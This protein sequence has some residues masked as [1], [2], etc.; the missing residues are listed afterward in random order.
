LIAAHDTGVPSSAPVLPASA[1]SVRERLLT[2]VIFITVLTSSI[3]FVEPSPHDALMIVLGMAA[4]IAGVRFERLLAVPLLLLMVFDVSGLLALTNDPGNTKAVLFAVI[5]IYLALAALLWACLFAQNTM[6]RL[7]TMRTAYIIT[8]VFSVFLG[9]A[10]YFHLFPDAFHLF[11]D[12]GRAKAAFKDPNVYGPFLIWPALFIMYRMLAQRIHILDVGVLA[13]LAFGL[14]L[15]FSRGAWFHFAV[16]GPWPTCCCCFRPA[17]WG[18][19]RRSCARRGKT[20]P[21]P[22]SPPSSAK[23]PRVS[24]S[25]ATTG[26]IS[27][28]S[29]A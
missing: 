24:S 7:A 11:T 10:G 14:L 27:F 6:P 19:A 23:W 9:A 3:A 20:M 22:R 1:A 12:Y 26:G 21:L 4:L 8:A 17:P 15:S 13:I 5:S 25:T 18:C 16:S 2:A 29:S 28:C